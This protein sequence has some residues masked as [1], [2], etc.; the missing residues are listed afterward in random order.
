[1]TSCSSYCFVILL[2]LCRGYTSNT[3]YANACFTSI[4]SFGDSLAD[5]GNLKQIASETDKVISY[6]LPPYGE[7]F[8]HQPTGRCSDGRLIIDLLA[9]SLGLP[10]IPPFVRSDDVVELGQG[11]NYAVAGAT[12]LDS[13]FLE[14]K[15]VYN[16]MTNASLRVQLAWF[17]QSL[18]SL[19]GEIRD[20]KHLIGS[21]LILMGEIGGNDYNVP[22]FAGKSIDEVESYVPLVIDTIISAINELIEMGARTLVVPGNLP[23]GCT[24]AYLA[25]FGSQ[26]E[27]YDPTTDCLIR[28]NE[29]AEYHNE[30][31]QTELMMIQELHPN[32]IIIYADYYNAVMQI[33]RSPHKFGFTNG[34]LKACCGGGGPFNYNSSMKCGLAYATVCDQPDTYVNWDGVHL[35][36]AAYKHIF[37]GLFQGPYTTPQ[38]NSLCPTST[39]STEEILSRSIIVELKALQ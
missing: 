4:I 25:L 8:F 29:I 3:L 9:E 10:L 31:L 26:K 18:P 12:A 23:I 7:T 36:E 17:K 35:T 28:Y 15:G 33:Y 21:S 5:T 22:F 34:A 13:P 27:K 11:V 16:S 32:V 1:M 37:K 30:L 24:S 19:C 2:V 6:F 39:S 38:F 20:C 14:A